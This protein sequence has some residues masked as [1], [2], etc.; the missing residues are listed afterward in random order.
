MENVL[1]KFGNFSY[2]TFHGGDLMPTLGMHK[3]N[4]KWRA[5]EQEANSNDDF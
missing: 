3:E 4:R 1:A 2:V 5:P